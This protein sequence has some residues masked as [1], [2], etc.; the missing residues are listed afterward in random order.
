MYNASLSGAVWDCLGKLPASSETEMRRADPW[1]RNHTDYGDYRKLPADS[2]IRLGD[3]N[4]RRRQRESQIP[5][6]RN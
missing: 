1:A 3:G 4:L 2:T 5:F 6:T